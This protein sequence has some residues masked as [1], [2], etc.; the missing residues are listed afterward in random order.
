MLRRQLGVTLEGLGAFA[1]W[2]AGDREAA[3]ALHA[4]EPREDAAKR[5]LLNALRAAFVLPMEP[6][7][8][9]AL[10]RGIAWILDHARDLVREAEAMAIEP[11]ARIAEMATLLVEAVRH[12]DEAIAQMGQDGDATAAA[13]AAIGSER[14]LEQVYYEGM[15]GLLGVTERTE[16]IA[17]RE[18][19]RGC[20]RIGESVVEVAERI[21]YSVVKQ[22]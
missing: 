16:R 17:L 1:A 22:S 21:V 8:V 18:L 15:A 10:S 20:S 5:E 3:R 11:D 7:D 6:E 12:I 19:Y 13:D 14:E 4:S 2:A 9:F